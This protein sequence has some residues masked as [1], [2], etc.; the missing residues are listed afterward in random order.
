MKILIADNAGFCFGVKRAVKMAYDQ[1]NNSDD[2]KT[3]SYGELI[4]NPQV[5]KDLEDKGIKTIEHIDELDE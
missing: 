2:S 5:V 3:Y 4:H 1:V